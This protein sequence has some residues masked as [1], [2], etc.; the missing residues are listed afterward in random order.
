ML[1]AKD[2]RVAQIQSSYVEEQQVKAHFQERKKR[3][4]ARR[5]SFLCIIC[6]ILFA[7]FTSIFISQNTVITDKE[8][9][10][11]ELEKQLS[12]MEKEEGKLKEEIKKLN[13]PEYVGE[14]AR[15][16]YFYSKPGETIFKLPSS[17]GTN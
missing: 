3:G 8:Q 7:M 9:Q 4:L 5:L 15:R 14:I 1:S 6:G 17:N 13:N 11:K 10:K 16:D 2:K 12:T